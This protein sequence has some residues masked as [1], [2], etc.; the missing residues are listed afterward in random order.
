MDACPAHIGCTKKNG[1]FLEKRR[2]YFKKHWDN[3]K[4]KVIERARSYQ[5]QVTELEQ[6][7]RLYELQYEGL[8]NIHKGDIMVHLLWKEQEQGFELQTYIVLYCIVLY[9]IMYE[10]EY[11]KAKN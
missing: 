3:N 9:C 6:I 2:A 7:E 4:E 1:E 8:I 5:K 10:N 11:L